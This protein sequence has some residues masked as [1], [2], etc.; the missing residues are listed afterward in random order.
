MTN[1]KE[2]NDNIN[3]VRTYIELKEEKNNSEYNKDFDYIENSIIMTMIMIII[4]PL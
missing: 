4:I 3:I 2:I 1:N